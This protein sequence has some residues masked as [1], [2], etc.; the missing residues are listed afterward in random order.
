MFKR[1]LIFASLF[2]LIFVTILTAGKYETKIFSFPADDIKKLEVSIELGAG[3]FLL[4]VG[5]IDE[6]AKANVEYDDRSVDV[7]GEY[8]KRGTTGVIEFESEI[9]KKF[10]I[11]TDDNNWDIVLSDKFPTELNIDIGACEAEI[12]LGGLPLEYLDFDVGAAEVDILF[13]RPNPGMAEEIKI[14]AGAVELKVEELGNANF[15]R[16]S[17]DGGAGDFDIDF[18]GEYKGKSRAKI[19]I[20][21]GSAKIRIPSDLPVRIETSDSFL[22]SVD[23]RHEDE[24]YLDGDDYYETK[25]FRRSDIGL[26]LE[27]SVGLGSIEIIFED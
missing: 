17:F 4:E 20:G 25:D 12:D 23:F 22:S 26:D 8:K 18:S 10:N 27:V 24:R 9:R 21:L 1:S 7:Y 3:E 5:N 2:L 16:L 15:D 11:D 13:S 6:I 14:D 19:S